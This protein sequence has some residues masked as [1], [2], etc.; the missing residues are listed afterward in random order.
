MTSRL[1][2]WMLA[3][4]VCLALA[5]AMAEVAVPP[6][7]SPVTD[8][9]GTLT[10][11]Q[12]S[13]LE[14][15]LLAMEREK[16][17]QVAVLIV[18]TTQPEP[19][20]MYAIRVA[21]AW[22]LGREGVDDGVLIVL[23][24][25]D[26]A[27]RIEVGYGLEGVIPDAVGKR[28]IEEDMI[29]R[30]RAG[31]YHGG[32]TAGV[33]RIGGL[34]RGEALPVPPAKRPAGD[35]GNALFTLMAAGL[36]GGLFSRALFG[37]LLGGIVTAG[38]IGAIAWIMLQS[39]LFAFF[40]AVVVFVLTLMGGGGGGGPRWRGGYGGF[41]GTGGGWSSGGWRGGGGGFGGGGASGRW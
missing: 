17:A 24:K 13:A 26:R 37:R 10:S 41:P 3:L 35:A 14:Q 32:I 19:V 15:S 1:A 20:E 2:R 33:A 36:F 11:Q 34:I 23:A 5:P 25:N 29:P 12:A 39:V 8:L 28:I 18:P 16:G 31:D 38:V 27:V 7:R 21:E 40:A 6:L 9:T 30:F 22:Q 4:G